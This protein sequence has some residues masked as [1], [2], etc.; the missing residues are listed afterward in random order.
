MLKKPGAQ[1]GRGTTFKKAFQNTESTRSSSRVNR[2]G[3]GVTEGPGWEAVLQAEEGTQAERKVWRTV[4]T[5]AGKS[6][7]TLRLEIVGKWPR[8]RKVTQDHV[9]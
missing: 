9:N 2:G 6:K 1:W 4:L 5:D 7:D 8:A 3:K